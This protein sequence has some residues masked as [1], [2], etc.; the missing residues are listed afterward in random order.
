MEGR[1]GWREGRRGAGGGGG[2]AGGGGGREGGGGGRA[3]RGG[4]GGRRGRREGRW[5]GGTPG[6][7]ACYAVVA[8][9]PGVVVAVATMQL[10]IAASISSCSTHRCQLSPNFGTVPKLGA[11]SPCLQRSTDL[12][13]KIKMI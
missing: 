1:R 12:S 11:L 9:A 7:A 3:G 4:G 10:A 8:E 5:S 2:G 13:P 6:T